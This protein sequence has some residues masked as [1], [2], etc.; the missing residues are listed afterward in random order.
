MSLRMWLSASVLAVGVAAGLHPVAG[1]DDSKPAVYSFGT[2]KT[3]AV[4]AARAQAQAWLEG[5]GKADD[6][7]APPS[8]RSGTRPTGVRSW[9]A[10]ARRWPWAAP[11][12]PGS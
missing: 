2:L 6:A 11:T 10:S 4:E 8:R 9:S 1:A 3:P 12:R 5:V 7:S